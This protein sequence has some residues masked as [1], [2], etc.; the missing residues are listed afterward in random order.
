MPSPALEWVNRA[1]ARIAER[2]REV[3]AWTAL[4]PA[5][6]R[7]A[8]LATPQDAPL[9]GL[10][11]GVKDVIDVAGMATG[12]NSPLGKTDTTEFAAAGRNAATAN[13]HALHRTPGGSSSGSAAAVAD[14]HVPIALATQTGGSTIRPA[15]F[16]GIPALKPTWGAISREGAKLYANSLDTIGL[17][18]ADFTLIALGQQ[19]IDLLGQNRR[20]DL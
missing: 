3:R 15:S 11:L 2:D 7:Q 9:Y 12:H 8:A 18:G 1:L 4:A 13:P 16:C 14:G 19:V 17:Y 10:V 5:A 6:A 20:L